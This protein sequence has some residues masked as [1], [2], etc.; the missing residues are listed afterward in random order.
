VAV[1]FIG[2]GNRRTRRKPPRRGRCRMVVRFT[3]DYAIS[4]YHRWYCE[5]ESRSGQGVQHYAI[6]FGNEDC[7]RTW[8]IWV[9]VSCWWNKCLC[10][11][12]MVFSTPFNNIS[13][14]SWRS[15][16][17][18]EET[19]GPGENLYSISMKPILIYS[20]YENNP[21]SYHIHVVIGNPCKYQIKI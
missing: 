21:H 16:L 5:F 3:A 2:G 15:V 4:A 10:V 18:V 1:S 12:L 17:L 13:A 14:I 8:N 19:G 20:M 11:C 9:W 6:K 7:F